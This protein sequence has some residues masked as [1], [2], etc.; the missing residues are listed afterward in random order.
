MKKRLYK[1][2]GLA[3]CLPVFLL[4]G[5][6]K[7]P[8]GY[9][10]TDYVY[11]G[12]D[13]TKD[14]VVYCFGLAGRLDKDTLGIE[15]RASGDV[16]GYDREYVVK[17]SANSTAK[18]G[19]DFVVLNRVFRG[20]RVADTMWIAVNNSA[21][22]RTGSVF[23]QLE[24]VANEQFELCFP[25]QNGAKV[26]LTDV[27]VRPDWWDGKQESEGL[28]TYSEKKYRLFLQVCLVQDFGNMEYA[29]RRDAMLRFRKYL[30]DEAKKGN[31]IPDEDGQPM[32]VAIY[33]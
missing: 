25:K 15:V 33:G 1:L 23:L 14:S 4:A 30:E 3:V 10:G 31:V 9:S 20:G 18:E 16:A 2:M 28:G 19:E 6:E 17:A 21:K 27:V 8:Q 13:M 24:L 11:F 29:E 12:K 7:D 26:Y 5:C 32:R 22:L